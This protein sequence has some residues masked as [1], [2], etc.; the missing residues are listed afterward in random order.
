VSDKKTSVILAGGVAKGA[1]EAGA[2]KVLSEHGV[3]ISHVVAASSGALNGVVYAAAVRAGR[4]HEAA[5]RLTSL[6]H[7][8]G[9]GSHA[10]EVSARDLLKGKGVSTT[11]RLVDLM[12]REVEAMTTTP[13]CRPVA[14]TLV[15]TA[16]DG[17]TRIVDS[18][19]ITTCERRQTFFESAFDTRDQ[20]ERI[21]AF[22]AASAAFPVLFAPVQLEHVGPCVD[23]GLVNNSP[24]GAAIDQGAER[25]ILIAPSPSEASTH[26][27]A[28]G[29]GLVLQLADILVGERLFRD[30]QQTERINFVLRALDQL[31]VNGSLSPE[32]SETVKD[33]LGWHSNVELI[34]IRPPKELRGSAF[35]GLCDRGLRAE[36]IAAGRSAARAAIDS[37][38]LA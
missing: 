11:A 8:E 3:P 35:S 7:N 10:L 17:E 6:W 32:Q 38:G 26:R 12:R 13:A 34:S 21:Y 22:A 28:S 1:F 37:H 24:I 2:L 5:T 15:T 16:V 14:L 27:D 23:G 19:P 18:Q 33:V 36:Y 4:E 9:D 20:R 29:V 25:V 31:T 30:L